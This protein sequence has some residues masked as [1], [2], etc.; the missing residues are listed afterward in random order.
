MSQ[1]LSRK[2]FIVLFV[3]LCT[4]VTV[5]GQTVAPL[6]KKNKTTGQDSSLPLRDV[7]VSLEKKYRLSILYRENLVENKMAPPKTVAGNNADT[8]L[9]ALLTPLGLTFK[10][11]SST[12]IVISEA[13]G[14]PVELSDKKTTGIVKKLNLLKGMVRNERNEPVQG[15]SVII[16]GVFKGTV[17]DAGGNYRLL[18]DE[19]T[20]KIYF[21]SVGYNSY[22]TSINLQHADA[23]KDVTLHNAVTDLSGVVVA[24]GSRAS[25][26]TFTTTSLPV[27]N[28][29]GAD[30]QSTGQLSFDKALQFRAPSFNTVNMPVHDATSL[31]DPYEIRNLGPSRTLILINGKRKNPGSLVYI[32]T[33]PGRGETETDLSAIPMDAIKRVEILRD[34][35]SAQYGSD[36]IAGVMNIILKDRFEY[37]SFKLSSGITH[38]G[39][40]FSVSTSINSGVNIGNKGFVN[41]TVNFQKEDRTNRP[42][43]VDAEQDFIDLGDGT[44][45]GLEKAKAFLARFP[46]A[47]NINGTPAI[48]AAKFLVN[49]GIPLND[50]GLVYANA[51]YVYKNIQSYAN[52][53]TA[54]WKQDPYNL[55]HDTTSEYLGYGPTFAG[56]LNDYNATLGFKYEKNNWNT[57]VSATAG[58]NQQLYSVNNTWNPSM[59]A[60]SPTTFRPGGYGFH[61]LVGN[62]D[63]THTINDKLSVGFGT[64]FRNE[65]FTII[66]GDRASWT[67]TGPVSFSGI[68]QANAM[69]ANRFNIGGYFDISYDASKTLLL[70]ATVRQEYYNDFGSAFVWKVSGRKKLAADKITLRSSVSTGFRAPGLHQVN[71]QIS[72]QIFTPGMGVQTKGVVNNKSMQAQLLGVPALKPERS[73]NFTAGFGW[74]PSAGFSLTLDYYNIDIRNRII[75]S[76]NIAHTA[77]GNTQL[78]NVLSANGIIGVS[79]FTNGIGTNTQGLDLVATWKNIRIAPAGRL[80]VNV[81]GNYTLDNKLKGVVSNPKLIA[82]AGQ[83]IFDYMQEALL[84]TS[85]PKYKAIAGADLSLYK[86]NVS[87]NNTLF[88]PATFRSEG[89]D[90]NIKLVF[91]PKVVTDV[92][93]G[94]QFTQWLTTSVTVNNLFNILPQYSLK[95]LN[96]EGKAVL[97]DPANV[98]R[99]VNAVTFNGRYGIVTYD[100]S[101]F[102]QTG[103]TFL[104]TFSCKL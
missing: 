22:V 46:D 54:Y 43:N 32:Q 104:L 94:Y 37:T 33:S 53:R 7:L 44:A 29:N 69:K 51:A 66:A 18:L 48:T 28:I 1:N 55:L 97:N 89:L 34:G 79:F 71:L 21:S 5:H 39:D 93:L 85:R 14:M 86:W 20:H 65:T 57:D 6:D 58:G 26:R 30:L 63:I 75:L 76:S 45:A 19:G 64:E 17:T 31:S 81:A 62:I 25:Q 68:S 74:R 16:L 36:A 11:V 99:N 98:K 2:W 83:A 4:V 47:R 67:G 72:Q 73:L 15:A 10:K 12:Q 50:N 3:L 24:V 9:H 84:L 61:H 70:N 52:Y 23:I 60:Q 49:A 56:D 100:G 13:T 82:D 90:K 88:G 8:A 101:H 59:G 87:V 92:N 27:D 38:K 77:D 78:D 40:G 102:S 103:T 80:T 95:A 35:A 42:G 91:N 96:S 41:Y